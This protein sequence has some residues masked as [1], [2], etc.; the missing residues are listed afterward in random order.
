MII[1]EV[2]ATFPPE[3]TGMG[4]VCYQNS[5]QLKKLGNDVTVFTAKTKSNL[6]S[7]KPLVNVVRLKHLVRFGNAPILPDLF[8]VANYDVIHLHLPFFFGSEIIFLM[9]KFRGVPYVVTYHHDPVLNPPLNAASFFYKWTLF[10]LIGQA[11]SVFVTSLDYAY[12]CSVRKSL[13]DTRN[14]IE[15]PVGVDTVRFNPHLDG[16]L[17]REKLAI[18]N[19]ATVILF[20]GGLDRPHY[21]K[22]VQFLISAFSKLNKQSC[23][24]IIV[25]EGEL[26][27]HFM[28][29]ARSLGVEDRIFFVGCV[30]DEALPL[31][32]ACS[33]FLVLPSSAMSEAFGK[34]LIEAMACGKAVIASNLPGVRSVVSEWQNG[35]LAEPADVD[36]LCSTMR[37]LI[38][39]P[40]L[41][42][43]FGNNGREKVESKY[44]WEKVGLRLYSS[45]KEIVNNYQNC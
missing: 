16:N 2:V 7:F 35:L 43:K 28:Q 39:D 45:L 6:G 10:N 9:S 24:L 33:D 21:F 34:V 20:V 27:Y 36:D 22:G 4:N 40:A 29:L 23:Y 25:G 8:K 26:K 17:I 19:N 38:D 41:R 44:N 3:R 32:Y 1:A 12:N 13:S 30:S 31:Y 42:K 5:I 37:V 14:L 15:L 11:K 18:S